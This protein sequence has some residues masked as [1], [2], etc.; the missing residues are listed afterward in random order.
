MD[1]KLEKCHLFKYCKNAVYTGKCE[2]CGEGK[3]NFKNKYETSQEL[4]DVVIED[5]KKT[6]KIGED[7]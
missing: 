3:L 4:L 7:E 1:G 2:S 6:F 5:F